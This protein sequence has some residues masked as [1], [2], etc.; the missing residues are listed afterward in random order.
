MIKLLLIILSFS[1]FFRIGQTEI[2]S[3]SKWSMNHDKDKNNACKANLV[4]LKGAQ[5]ASNGLG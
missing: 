2:K 4:F 1:R 3:V 5:L